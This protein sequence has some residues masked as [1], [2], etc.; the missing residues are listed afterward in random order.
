S[1]G[2]FETVDSSGRRYAV[3]VH[4]N[5][6]FITPDNPARRGE[7]IRVYGTGLGAVTPSAG[8]NAPGVPNQNVVAQILVGF[9]D[10]GVTPITSEYAENLIGVN[11]VTF[12]MPA[13]AATGAQR[14]LVI[15]VISG[16]Q[17]IFSNGS[18]IAVQ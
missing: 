2:L 8:T 17:T 15:A 4:D 13:D 7:R 5:G 10:G 6:A 12:Q 18:N 16:G 9:N 1:P 11:V 14:N 3:A